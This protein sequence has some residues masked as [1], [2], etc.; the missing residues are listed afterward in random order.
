MDEHTLI[1]HQHY[2]PV[3]MLNPTE[4]RKRD[5]LAILIEGLPDSIELWMDVWTQRIISIM[6]PPS[7]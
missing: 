1:G 2:Q 7:F 5:N 4:N 6:Y 3:V